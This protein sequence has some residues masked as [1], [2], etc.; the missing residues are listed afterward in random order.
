[1]QDRAKST[2]CGANLRAIGV[3][4]QLFAQENQ[5][6]LPTIEGFPS[7]P[8]YP[9]DYGSES[10]EGQQAKVPQTMI[11]A[12]GPYGVTESTLK[13]PADNKYFVQEGTSYWWKPTLDEELVSNPKI[14]GRHGER[15]I[16]PQYASICT[17]FYKIHG[18]R[19]NERTNR[20]Y[21]DG[22]V[23]TYY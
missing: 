21:L 5:N 3:S 13:C 14:Y 12:L 1:M 7:D 8:I 23:K 16:P 11:E 4:V 22:H 9:I 17:D 10:D 15:S 6:R 19:G 2:A 18:P 20:L